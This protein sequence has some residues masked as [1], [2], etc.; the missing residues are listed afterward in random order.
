[1]MKQLRPTLVFIECEVPRLIVAYSRT[2]VPS[3]TSTHVCSPRNLRSCGSP[4]RMLPLPILTRAASTTLRSS[5]ARAPITH[6]SATR[7]PGPTIA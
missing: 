4:P 6:P 1:M 3:P 7:Q 5:V 2:V